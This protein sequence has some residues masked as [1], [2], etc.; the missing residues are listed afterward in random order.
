M[1]AFCQPKKGAIIVDMKHHIKSLTALI[2]VALIVIGVM[3][4][5]SW[6][7]QASTPTS[8]NTGRSTNQS[9]S[10]DMSGWKTYQD[11]QLGISLKYPMD[12][13]LALSSSTN[14]SNSN[15]LLR[16]DG[17]E[18]IINICNVNDCAAAANQQTYDQN[19]WLS[20]SE[21][22]SLNIG[23]VQSWRTIIPTANGEDDPSLSFN[24]TFLRKAGHAWNNP[25]FE[26]TSKFT[27]VSD[28]INSN[29]KVYLVNYQLPKTATVS[30]YDHSIISQMDGIAQ[31]IVFT[32]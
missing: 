12:W 16:K 19:A 26:D 2:I 1:D 24:F 10:T 11:S 27:P 13:S 20:P 29:G 28:W 30:D 9:Q 32:H 15:V 3:Y 18:M 23:G 21:S 4:V 14:S 8:R 17:Y 22:V 6:S 25:G 5:W 7:S 31:S